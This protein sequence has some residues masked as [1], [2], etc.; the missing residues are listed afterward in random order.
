MRLTLFCAV[1]ACAV[2]PAVGCRSG[3]DDGDFGTVRQSV[4]ERTGH[5]IEWNL[6]LEDGGA[7]AESVRELLARDLSADEAVQV[8]LLNN[9]R[10]QA[11]YEDLGIARSDLVQAGLLGNPVFSGSVRWGHG[12]SPAIE[13]AVVQ[14]FLDVFSIPLRRRVAAAGLE[15][16]KSRVT[17]AV[18]DMAWETR[19]TCHGLQADMGRLAMHRRMLEAAEASYD[20]TRRLHKAGNITD[21]DLA[22][23]RAVYEEVKLATA[24]AELAVQ[25][26]RERLTVLM[27]LYGRDTAWQAA[28]LPGLPKDELS[29]E[30]VERRAVEA[31]LD[32]AMARSSAM[33]AAQRLGAGR[34]ERLF[35][36]AGAGATATRE[37]GEW[38]A[39][40]SVEMSLPLF[41]WGQG[42]TSAAQ[43]ELR[44]RWRDY[45]AT[46]VE[47]RSAARAARNR[48]IAHRQRVEHHEKVVLPLR[49][50]ITAQTLLEYNAMQIGPVQ[51]LEAMRAETEARAQAVEALRDYWIARAGME[52]VLNG[53]IPGERP[54]GPA[55]LRSANPGRAGDGH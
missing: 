37:N 28:P 33:A 2:L 51:L 32:L 39:G 12:A 34:V 6:R 35:D 10:V 15:T 5:A 30:H 47:V 21:L 24:S 23:E 19:L 14:T 55:V 53:R 29:L 45:L 9:R 38:S 26:A 54:S 8:A 41:D 22:R 46:A 42:Q 11:V 13:L 17:A 40:P 1:S 48:L 20:V 49:E 44:R 27:G 31:S 18:L 52:Q 50:K 43:A 7:V 16:A 4:R 36:G 3:P 25:D